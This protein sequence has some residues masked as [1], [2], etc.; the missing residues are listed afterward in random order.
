MFINLWCVLSCEGMYIKVWSCVLWY[1]CGDVF[2][3]L[4]LCGFFLNNDCE[5]NIIRVVIIGDMI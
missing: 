2:V 3:V 1:L 5:W 4:R